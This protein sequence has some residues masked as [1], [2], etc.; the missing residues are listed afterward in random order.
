MNA[1][2]IMLISAA[3][4]TLISLI[5]TFAKPVAKWF[6]SIPEDYRGLSMVGL[7]LLAVLALFGLSCSGLF[8]FVACTVA[9]AKSLLVA[10]L[11]MIATNQLTYMVSPASPT[12]TA[13][14]AKNTN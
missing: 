6:Y 2:L 4:G 9:S 14:D 13:L 10:F 1:D 5:V 7:N 11:T 3:A 12:K 8:A